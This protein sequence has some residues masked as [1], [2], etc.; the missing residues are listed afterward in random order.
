MVFSSPS[1]A[2]LLGSPVSQRSGPAGS[3][4]TCR[5]RGLAVAGLLLTASGGLVFA[6][7]QSP[8]ELDANS[9]ADGKTPHTVIAALPLVFEENVGQASKNVQFLSRGAGFTLGLSGLET[10]LSL[11][12]SSPQSASSAPRGQAERNGGKVGPRPTR[13]ATVKTRL[14]GANPNVK[15]RGEK[16]LKAKINYFIGSDPKKWHTDVP[17]YERVRTTDAYPGIDVVHYGQQSGALEYDFVVAPNVDPGQIRF[18]VEGVERMKLAA[19]GDLVL[20]TATGE[21]RQ[22]RPVCYQQRDGVRAP[23]IGEFV[24]GDAPAANCVSFRIGVYDVAEPLIIDPVLQYS[25]YL[26]G[27]DND[28]AYDLAVDGSGKAFVT[29]LTGSVDFPTTLTQYQPDQT[30]YDAFVTVLDTTVSGTASV[31]YST[32]L[33]GGDFDIGYSIATDGAGR[34]FVTGETLSTNFPT[35]GQYQ[36]DPGDASLDAFVTV[37]DTTAS[38]AASLLYSTYLG[39]VGGGNNADGGMGIATDGSGKAFVTGYTSAPDFPTL[40]QYQLDQGT[41]DAFVTVLD[42]TATGSASLL[43]STYLGGASLENGYGIATDGTGKAFVMGETLSTGFPN[44]GQYQTYQGNGDIFVTVL[45]TTATGAASLLYSTFLGGAGGDSGGQRRGIATD[46]AGKAFVTG[47]TSSADFPTLGQY[48]SDQGGADAFVTVLDTTVTGSASLLYST[49]LGGSS[50]DDGRAIATDG[51]GNAFV[52]GGTVSTDFP[53]QSPF[54]TDQLNE[55]AFVAVLDTTAT[56]IASFVYSTYLGGGGNDVGQGIAIDGSGKVFVAGGTGSSNFPTQN[57]A[58]TDPG[59]SNGDGFVTV[60]D[61]SRLP[62][63]LINFTATANGSGRIDLAWIDTNGNETGY[64]IERMAQD[65]RWV[66]GTLPQNSTSMV[67]LD[68][69][70]GVT[71]YYR[72]RAFNTSGVSPWSL[73]ASATT[74]P[75]IPTAPS[76]LY[77]TATV[78]QQLTLR[79]TDNA[80]NETGFLLQ[81]STDRANWTQIVDGTSNTILFTDTGLTTGATYYYRVR[82]YNSS[83]PSAWSETATAVVR[84]NPPGVPGQ[85][86][87]QV[88]SSH[89]LLTWRDTLTENFFRVEAKPAGGSFSEVAQTGKDVTLFSHGNLAASSTWTYRV[90]GTNEGGTSGYSEEFTATTLPSPPA[91]PSNLVMT[92]LSSAVVSLTWTDNSTNETEFRIERKQGTSAY[93]QIAQVT[94]NGTGFFD[95]AVAPSTNYTYRIRAANTGGA[96]PYSNTSTGSTLANMT[97]GA[98]EVRPGSVT[99]TGVAPGSSARKSVTVRNRGKGP[100]RVMAA[101]LSAP[102]AVEGARTFT[103]KPNEKRALK[104]R[105]TAPAHGKGATA[106][107]GVAGSGRTNPVVYIPVTA[108]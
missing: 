58:Q 16:R 44:Q 2:P 107:L 53:T 36:T 99:F 20:T 98:L 17:A 94:A 65:G 22:Q 11:R 23:V 105:Y 68:V 71:Y 8:M 39:G 42:T 76:G 48:Q 13:S 77:A 95:A 50:N 5:V 97:R 82:A 104:V 26:G 43:Y 29:G 73:I 31:L 21:L 87:T 4:A 45:D 79:W 6:A 84:R 14:V 24:L 3:L 12:D 89:I 90:R 54:Q 19:N 32:Y 60:L 83:G 91:A 1:G 86:R 38:G 56:G 34:A 106:S 64:E 25:T 51:F 70:P 37:L 66:T 108:Q 102:F 100:L 62:K 18:T 7:R 28:A 15:T 9:R 74:L 27:G 80:N 41:L 101:Q 63:S 78:A 67:D 93:A 92:P 59:D 81:R 88:S 35:L 40:G 30:A 61:L 47:Y 46:G 52:T 85:L 55:D 10:V 33:G 49:Y 75:A 69:F 96:S 57:Q 72:G 103:L